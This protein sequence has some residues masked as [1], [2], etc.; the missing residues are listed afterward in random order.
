M[1]DLLQERKLNLYMKLTGQPHSWQ[2]KLFR[3]RCCHRYK[4]KELIR[5]RL[6]VKYF[7]S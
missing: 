4:L 5:K 2:L 6:R 7:F 1:I 3:F